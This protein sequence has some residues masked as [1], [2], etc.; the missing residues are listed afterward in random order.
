[1][2]E[3]SAISWTRSTFNPWVGCTKVGPGCDSCY[4]DALDVKRFSKTL[5]GATSEIPIRHWGTGAPR[6]RTSAHNWNEPLRWNRKAEEEQRTGVLTPQS[7]WT[8]RIGHW[9]VFCASLADVFDNEVDPAW[10]T[11]LWALIRATPALSWLLVTKR[12]GN[13]RD[14]VPGIWLTYRFE[15][16]VRLLIT[17]VNQAEADRDVPKLLALPCWNGISY[18]PALGGVDWMPWMSLPPGKRPGLQWI[19]VGGESKQGGDFARAFNG[20]W[21]LDA[22]DQCRAANVPVFMKQMGSRPMWQRGTAEPSWDEPRK[23]RAGADPAEWPP[24]LR[25]QEMPS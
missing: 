17:V 16:N 14:M 5:G 20:Y 19:I 24:A 3:T 4:A 2:A 6:H 18:E 7:T 21:A 11:D 12:I 1:M 10:R 9:P 8:G 23:D 22:I 13:V 15:D 25:V